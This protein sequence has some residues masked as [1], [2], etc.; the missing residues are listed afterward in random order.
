M[1]SAITLHD[2]SFAWPDG[3]V[4]LDSVNGSFP[5]GRTGLVGRN[6]A[7]K[8]T[9]LKLMAGIL[10][11]T[12]GRIDR[13]TE[14]GYLPQNLTLHR[15]TTVAQLLGIEHVLKALRAIE[16]GDIAQ[17]HFDTVGDDWD[18]ES[19][20]TEALDNLG[21][22]GEVLHRQVPQLSGG[23]AMLIAVTGLRLRRF[24]VTLLDEPTNNLDR[25]TR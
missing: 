7:G 25:P 19:R 20:A 6:G 17:E 23:E 24:G 1:K 13:G 2:L 12:G 16:A 11:P 8:S 3:A 9:L 5:T 15:T 10:T 14:V 18:I 21:F 4:V 22:R